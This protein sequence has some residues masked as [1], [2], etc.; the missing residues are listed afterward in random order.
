MEIRN[1]KDST[2]YGIHSISEALEQGKEF[3]KIYLQKGSTNKRL[4]DIEEIAK[5]NRLT[6]S[7]VPIEKLNKLSKHNN[8]QGVVG[9]ISQ[10]KY[11]D[12]DETL[13]KITETNNS[14][15]VLLL[16]H[17]TDVRNFG[18]IIRTAVSSGVDVIVIPQHGAASVT[19]EVIKT[20]V[21][22]AY[23]IPICKVNHIKDAMFILDSYEI[24]TV[25]ATEK[26]TDTIYDVDLTGGLGIIMGSEHKGVNPSILKIV[27]HKAKVPM[28]N[29]MDSLNVSVAC[30]IFLFEAV[31]QRLS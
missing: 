15:F 26:A 16:D 27:T 5:K 23:K 9:I 13:S 8:H 21:G 11:A 2:I 7:F 4:A 3:D 31:R 6:F 22:A 10:L 1:K 28:H 20:S 25:A 19:G 29:D 18:A 14:P 17:I 12:L 30:G 24:K